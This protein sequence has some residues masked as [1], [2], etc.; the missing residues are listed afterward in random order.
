MFDAIKTGFKKARNLF[1]SMFAAKGEDSPTQNEMRLDA[2]EWMVKR[3]LG[4]SFFTK[5]LNHNTRTARIASL[6][7]AE[8]ELAQARGWVR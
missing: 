8:T 2:D 7:Q 1:S 4:K 3:K 5:Q 6:N